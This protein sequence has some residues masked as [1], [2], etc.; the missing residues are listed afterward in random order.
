MFE[1]PD[2]KFEK[3]SDYLE[4]QLQLHN[5]NKERLLDIINNANSVNEKANNTKSSCYATFV[6]DANKVL[7]TISNNISTIETLNSKLQNLNVEF[8]SIATIEPPK[9]R[10]K[11]IYLKNC[12]DLKD[13]LLEYS[14]TFEEI[15][16]KL[17]HDNI[18]FTE[19]IN[20]VN[21]SRVKPAVKK[22][23]I[24]VEIEPEDIF[25]DIEYSINLDF[26]E[27]IRNITTSDFEE[28]SHIETESYSVSSPIFDLEGYE[29][30]KVETIESSSS[31][32][33]TEI[34]ECI[35]IQ[36]EFA[37]EIRKI[38]KLIDKELIPEIRNIET[39]TSPVKKSIKTRKF[40][41]KKDV[42]EES[43]L[44][45]IGKITNASSDN[46]SL[47]ISEK[48]DKIYLPYKKSEL[49]SYIESN[50]E[51]YTSLEDVVKKEFTLPFSFFKNQSSK[52][53]FTEAYKLLRNKDSQGFMKSVSYA[54]EIASKKNLNPVVIAACKNK[55]ELE[56]YIYYLESNNLID[57]KFFDIIY[58]V[59]PLKK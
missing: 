21:H 44:D 20:R 54:F 47:I 5:N 16:S 43:I 6:N 22:V 30:E 2:F 24:E 36:E 27:K 15:E 13:N 52:A 28:Y 29:P 55:F 42:A 26:V 8:N 50:P 32:E 51:V 33:T 17:N 41:L 34:I 19:F 23:E 48:L 37:E 56:S 12:T 10:G 53:R 58:E 1:F 18:F 45:K 7:E 46:K 39:L 38:D 3:S 57:F 40:T 31:E 4:N 11:K 35:E 14:K 9:T 59:N 25:K 49:H